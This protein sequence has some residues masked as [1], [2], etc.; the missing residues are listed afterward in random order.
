MLEG[1][2]AIFLYTSITGLSVH[3][4]GERFQH[5]NDTITK[6]VIYVIVDMLSNFVAGISN[7]FS[8]HLPPPHLFN[9]CPSA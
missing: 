5:S 7:T 8:M 2:L 9:V 6:Y 4:V 1:Q 3:H